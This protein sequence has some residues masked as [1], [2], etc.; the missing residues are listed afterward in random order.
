[1]IEKIS[2]GF[3]SEL[4]PYGVR[5]VNIRSGGSPDSKPFQDAIAADKEKGAAFIKKIE[6]DTMLKKMPLMKDIA[7]VAVFLASELA[8]GITGVTIDVTCGTT[9]SLN[10]KLTPMAFAHYDNFKSNE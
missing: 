2:L 4:G 7:G 8:S 1:V 9:T 10:Y 5:V 6:D 3:A